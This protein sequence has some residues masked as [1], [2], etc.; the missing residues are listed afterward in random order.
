MP[1][2]SSFINLDLRTRVSVFPVPGRW[3]LMDSAIVVLDEAPQVV[4][5]SISNSY[6]TT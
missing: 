3:F 5:L 6:V 2:A 4:P 1:P